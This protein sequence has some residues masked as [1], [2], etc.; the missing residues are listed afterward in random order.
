M[1]DELRSSQKR[2]DDEMRK[3]CLVIQRL[4]RKGGYENRGTA[5]LAFIRK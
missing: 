5:N 2:H 4:D 3:P 1:W